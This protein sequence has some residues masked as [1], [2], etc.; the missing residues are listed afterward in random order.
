[1]QSK[2]KKKFS[3]LGIGTPVVDYLIPVS[4]SYLSKLPGAKHGM[5]PINYETFEYILKNSESAPTLIAGGSCSN[6][7]K[8]LA[9]LGHSCALAGKIGEDPA[10]E[11]F[12]NGLN[13]LGIVS[14][15]SKTTTPTS[16]VIALIDPDGERTFRCLLDAGL[17]MSKNDLL[18][19]YFR[20]I[21]HVH[22]EGYSLLCRDVTETAMRMAKAAGA[23]VSFDLA[24]FEITQQYKDIIID[25]INQYVNI[26]F[27]NEAE[28]FELT[29]ESPEE[30]CA[31]L[32][33]L[34]EVAVI[35]RGKKGSLV[36]TGKDLISHPVLPL[37]EKPLDTTGAG[38]LFA[39]GFLHGYLQGYP[40]QQA[41]R[42]GSILGSAVIQVLGAEIPREAWLKINKLLA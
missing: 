33:N 35:L 36:G 2:H 31:W 16:R 20:C 5:Q 1:M 10:G 4:H 9:Y 15:L 14:F 37:I 30:S 11:Y 38:D 40:V 34:C 27:A 28:S 22:I 24:S 21:S 39:S 23:T 12:L 42:F 18:P 17:E 7:L 29:H 8:G 26:V 32:A 41:A 19:E 25:L 3:I 13:S 6:T